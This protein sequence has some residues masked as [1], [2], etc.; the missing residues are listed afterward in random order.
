[1]VWR[2]ST[3]LE[4][5]R[6]LRDTNAPAVH[7]F[8]GPAPVVALRP[9]A[10]MPAH[11]IEKATHRTQ[12][13][14]LPVGGLFE[15]DGAQELQVADVQQLLLSLQRYRFVAMMSK[16]ARRTRQLPVFASIMMC[17]FTAPTLC[18]I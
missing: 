8:K 7:S 6:L 4:T 13:P 12:R 11:G 10:E 17:R 3:I 9:K 5:A 1:M 15:G 16:I 2:Q 14:P 18:I